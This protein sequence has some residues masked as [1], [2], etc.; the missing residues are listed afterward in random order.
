[1]SKKK[2]YS[3]SGFSSYIDRRTLLKG[4]IKG[5]SVA[6]ALPLLDIMLN[7]NGTA[8]A[9]GGNLPV[10]FGVFFWGN[11][12][13]SNL[14]KWA[15]AQNGALGTLPSILKPFE[16][17]SIV[18]TASL[19]NYITQI[20]KLNH[21]LSKPAHAVWRSIALS[22]SHSSSW[23]EAT[24]GA[25]Y[26]GAPPLPSIDSLV[27]NAW[28][29]K[30]PLDWIGLTIHPESPG[31][32]YSSWQKNGQAKEFQLTPS[33]LFRK[34]FIDTNASGT[35]DPIEFE[36]LKALKL[37]VLDA[38]L[39]SSASLTSKLGAEDKQRLEQHLESLREL[40]KQVQNSKLLD[41]SCTI[42]EAPSDNISGASPVE[43]SKNKTRIMAE[44][45]A[46]AL[47]CDITRVFCF[48]FTRTQSYAN[49][50]ALTQNKKYHD[51]SHKTTEAEK[52]ALMKLNMEAFA[53]LAQAL[54]SKKDNATSTILDNSLIMG[55]S[56]HTTVHNNN[57]HPYLFVGK[58]GGKLK[59][60]YNYVHPSGDKDN[61]AVR[62]LLTAA[63]SVGVELPVVGM[64]A[65]PNT[66]EKIGMTSDFRAT[67][68]ITDIFS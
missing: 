42:P 40:E 64:A 39:G 33:S 14:S 9:Q 11:G 32:Y 27:Q 21:K 61:N 26:R 49:F 19:K 7:D 62:A 46:M 5:T 68:P 20:S 35:G 31:Q 23:K 66:G 29:G 38:T 2:F 51:M 24:P 25:G 4:T 34:L 65:T 57:S 22:G 16:D 10:R 60:G 37:S 17:S 12:G 50:G 45:L 53:I 54:R 48:E 1:M 63:H 47:H 18:G 13:I 56:E 52:D 28:S 58:A 15:P 30:A 41:L 59:G 44:L 55:T 8:L 36:R 3:R 43:R 67:V 6:I